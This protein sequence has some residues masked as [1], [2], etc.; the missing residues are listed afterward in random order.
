MYSNYSNYPFIPGYL[1]IPFH[2][3]YQPFSELPPGYV[4]CQRCTLA[5]PST[6][7]SGHYATAHTLYRTAR[8]AANNNKVSYACTVCDK[9]YTSKVNLMSHVSSVHAQSAS[10]RKKYKCE[11]C[12]KAFK[13][14]ST[15]SHHKCKRG[16][17]RKM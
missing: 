7:M 4:Q 15:I 14:F 16:K 3:R 6:E 8:D 5:L 9:R 17:K 13:W 10:E 12:G 2:T 11:K 1:Q